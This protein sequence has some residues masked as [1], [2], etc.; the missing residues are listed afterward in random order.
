[1]LPAMAE[2]YWMIGLG[3]ESDE[4]LGDISNDLGE[5]MQISEKSMFEALRLTF[6]KR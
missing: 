1:M 5:K 4:T 2:H 3:D 6:K